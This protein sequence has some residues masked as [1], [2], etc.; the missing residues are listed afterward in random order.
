VHQGDRDG[1][2]ESKNGNVVPRC[3]DYGHIPSF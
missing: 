2:V 1:E 3:F